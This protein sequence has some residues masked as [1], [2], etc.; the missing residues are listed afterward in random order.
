MRQLI[1]GLPF[2]VKRGWR[3][4]ACWISGRSL[5]LGDANRCGQ[6]VKRRCSRFHL[7]D[8]RRVLRLRSCFETGVDGNVFR[9]FD[10]EAHPVPANFENRNFDVV[11]KDNLL[12]LFAAYDQHETLPLRGTPL[13]PRRNYRLWKIQAVFEN[14]VVQNLTH[15]WHTKRVF[16]MKKYLLY[17]TCLIVLLTWPIHAQDI[18]PANEGPADL[19]HPNAPVRLATVSETNYLNQLALKGF[20]LGTQGLLIESLDG[21]TVYADLN[22]SIGFNPASV[23]KVAT[24]FAALAKLG[25][26][27]HFETS[28]Y[29]DGVINKKTRTLQGNLIL[30]SS[31]DPVLSAIDVARLVRDVVRAGITGVSGNLIVTGPFTYGTY[32]N[33]AKAVNA[34]AQSLRRAGVRTGPTVTGGSPRGTKIASHVSSSLRDILFYQNA[35]SVNPIAERLG[36]A[37]G[38]PKAV[39]QFLVKDLGISPNDIAIS[40]TSGLEYNRITARATVMMFRELVFWLNLNNM[41]PQDVLPV[42]GVDAGTLQRRFTGQEYRGAVIGKT[43]TLPATDGGVSTLAGI[44]YTKDYGPLLFAIFNTNGPVAAYRKLQDDFLKG[45]IA[46]SGGIPDVSASLHRLNN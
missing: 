41:Q 37:L 17:T 19:T 11:S 2:K 8:L 5:P 18:A 31:G 34:L 26:E 13:F 32:Y 40:R 9:C 24:S 38:G 15:F 22:S 30:Q 4:I 20:K 39:E 27:Y 33:T 28:F 45:F 14:S 44:V 16:H 23:I 25:P 46:E 21:R 35:H 43:G 1:R 7:N 36:E 29:T 6:P 3:Q 12:A 42:A 10:S